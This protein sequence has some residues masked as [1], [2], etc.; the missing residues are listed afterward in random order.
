MGKLDS[1]TRKRV[2]IIALIISLCIVIFI[3]KKVEDFKKAE[4]KALQEEIER[5]EDQE[6]IEKYIKLVENY[7]QEEYGSYNKEFEIEFYK[8]QNQA[9]DV[10]IPTADTTC[11]IHDDSVQEYLFTYYPKENKDI[12]GCVAVRFPIEAEEDVSV[13]ELPYGYDGMC[14]FAPYDSNLACME[15]KQK[16][17]EIVKQNLGEQ[18]VPD[19][20]SD[21]YVLYMATD[22]YFHDLVIQDTDGTY[23]TALE[24]I[25]KIVREE[26]KIQE[27]VIKYKE[28]PTFANSCVEIDINGDYSYVQGSSKK[29]FDALFDNEWI[30]EELKNI[31]EEEDLELVDENNAYTFNYDFIDIDKLYSKYRNTELMKKIK[32]V[33]IKYNQRIRI[34]FLDYE[35]IISGD[36]EI[37]ENEIN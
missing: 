32:D 3:F 17:I 5:R 37:E 23:K 27:I 35:V 19:I 18:Y 25:D 28:N 7:V 31:F 22:Q 13:V 29:Q 2:I 36:G 1:K 9:K 8:K 34:K 30:L 20:S 6:K 10:D 14:F 24:T 12:K 33:A 21:A 15:R 26:L 4:Q 11:Y 16:A